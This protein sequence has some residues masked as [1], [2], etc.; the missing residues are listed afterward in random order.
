MMRN[1]TLHAGLLIGL[2]T[3]AVARADES[4]API[5][6]LGNP[7]K[8][9]RLLITKP[10]V[11]ENFLVDSQG[12]TG[13]RVKI[14]ANDVTLRNC[15]IRNA[16]GNGIGIFA[17]RVTIESCHIHHLLAGSF[18]K[19][20]DAHGITGRWGDVTIRNC[21]IHHV[22][23]DCIQL[24]PDRQ[25]SGKLLIESCTLWTGPLGKDTA[26]S[27]NGRFRTGQRPGENAVDTKTRPSG[28]RCRLTVRDCRMYGWKQPGQ[29]GLL[30]ALN[31]K[32]NVDAL[33]EGCVFEDNQ[34]CLRL[35]GPTR[36]GGAEVRIT[37]C[38]IHDSR[39][40]VRMED[41]LRN[42]KILRLGFGKNVERRHHRVG[43]GPFPG[44][45]NDGEHELP[46]R[47]RSRRG[48]PDA[49]RPGD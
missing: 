48:R 15:E 33:V 8:V 41:G 40:G 36:R 34:V 46:E 38:E 16:A 21:E 22:S 2:T 39:V 31:I 9:R 27:R 5:G 23:G 32:E 14:T 45:E 13:N 20:R 29:I 19:Q 24:D 3:V 35:R 42:L 37:G 7:K 6:C 18:E 28:P 12:A 44:Y 1:T 17:T 26:A 47:E 25:S 10:G 30:A 11:Y 49:S 43:R 4:R